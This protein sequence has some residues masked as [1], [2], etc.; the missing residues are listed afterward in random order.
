MPE[1]H[2]ATTVWSTDFPS[3]IGNHEIIGY[4]FLSV[5]ENSHKML[6]T[7]PTCK[8]LGSH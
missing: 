6:F 8:S 1:V 2:I 7:P 3:M 4:T 5:H